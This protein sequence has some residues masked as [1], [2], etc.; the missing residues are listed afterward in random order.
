MMLPVQVR[1][2]QA[3]I[4]QDLTSKLLLL[5][6]TTMSMVIKKLTRILKIRPEENLRRF[7]NVK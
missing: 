6:Q 2:I 7:I 5:L 4:S 1:H 3:G